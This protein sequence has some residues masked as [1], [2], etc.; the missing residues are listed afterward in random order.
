MGSG[1]GS[2]LEDLE[3]R[4]LVE[5]V[6]RHHGY[7]FRDYALASLK[8]RL[9][10]RMRAE[11]VATVSALQEK[12]LHDPDCLERFLLGLSVN[13]S[14]MFR[15]PQFHLA[16]RTIVVPLLRTY[17]SVRVWHAG[18]SMGEE[19]YSMAI[20]L[21]EEGLYD[22]SWIHATDMN[23]TVLKRAED[24]A[25]PLAPVPLFAANHAEAGGTR[26][27]SSYYSNVDGRAVV[28]PSLKKNLVFAQHNL[29]VD[30]PFNHFHVILCRNVMIYFNRE[31]QSRVHSLLLECLV[32]FGFLGLG[33]KESLKY[34]PHEARYEELDRQQKLYRRA[35]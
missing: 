3:V 10:D 31:L 25:Y 21:Q 7:D 6:Y 24:G 23:G 4:L 9:R 19:V 15:D 5:G 28:E 2:M 8:R 20:L 18:C 11:Q 26:P 30:G 29:A 13:V 34:T 17:P 35:R 14:S 12:V 1:A 33:S 16:F 27:F 22:R 32:L